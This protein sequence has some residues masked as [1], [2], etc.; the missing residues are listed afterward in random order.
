MHRC[1]NNMPPRMSRG[2]AK[3]ALDLCK[4]LDQLPT[5]LIMQL[6]VVAHWRGKDLAT[7]IVEACQE[8]WGHELFHAQLYLSQ[9]HEAANKV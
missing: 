9:T 6:A 3:L 4:Q 1:S 7:L 2:T 5:P 8:K